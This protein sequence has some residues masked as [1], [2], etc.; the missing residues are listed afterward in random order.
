MIHEETGP[1]IGIDFGSRD[2]ITATVDDKG[3]S[4]VIADA[5]GDTVLPAVVY[6][7]PGGATLVGEAALV[8]AT[9]PDRVVLDLHD[10]LA[11]RKWKLRVDGRSHRVVDVAEPIFQAVRVNAEGVVGPIAGVVV[12]VPAWFND[13]HRATARDAATRA[14]LPVAGLINDPAAAVLAYDQAEPLR[15]MVL[16][17]DLDHA[18]FDVTIIDVESATTLRVVTADGD[19]I[20]PGEPMESVLARTDVVLR[21]ALATARIE[22]ARLGAVILA[23]MKSNDDAVRAHVQQELDHAPRHDIDPVEAVARGA[24]VRAN[25]LRRERDGR[26]AA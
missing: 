7:E 16:V 20:A 14:G 18:T 17:F 1:V 9:D 6:F 15:G 10:H 5:A 8:A 21:R 23:G 3:Q 26:T 13:V 11:D 25:T 19:R 24:A 12:A 22:P 2:V 4:Q